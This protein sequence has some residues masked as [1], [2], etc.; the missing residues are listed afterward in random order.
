MAQLGNYAFAADP[1][2]GVVWRS[3]DN[4]AN[5]VSSRNGVP[6]F[7]FSGFSAGIGQAVTTV[8]TRVLL[9]TKIWGI[10]ASDDLGT[11]WVEANNGIALTPYQILPF[12]IGTAIVTAANGNVFAGIDGTIFYSTNQGVTWNFAINGLPITGVRRMTT[13]GAK[14]YATTQNSFLEID[15]ATLSIQRLPFTGMDT[16]Q[17]DAFYAHNGFLY[18][19]GASSLKRLSLNT[20]TRQN[21]APAFYL[22][23]VGGNKLAGQSQTFSA[24][25][26][27][28]LPI[29]YQWRKG[30]Q[31]ITGATNASYIINTLIALDAGTYDVVAT[32]PGGTATSTIASVS[33]QTIVPGAL[34]STFPPNTSA[35]G[36][37]SASVNSGTA[38]QMLAFDPLPGGSYWMAGQIDRVRPNAAFANSDLIRI[39]ADF[40]IAQD[41]LVGNGANPAGGASIEDLLRDSQGRLLAAG[42]LSHPNPNA[43]T[44]NVVRFLPNNTADSS[45]KLYMTNAAGLKVIVIKEYPGNKYII[46]GTFTNVQGQA[47]N[48]LARINQDGS[49]DTAFDPFSGLTG[50]S[51]QDV[52]V[53]PDGAVLAAGSMV[54]SVGEF[55][56]LLVRFTSAGVIDP[57]FTRIT[58]SAGGTGYAVLALPNGKIML[59]GDY[60][61]N[62]LLR[63]LNADGTT[64]SSFVQG[65]FGGSG[66]NVRAFEYQPDGKILVAGKFSSYNG[67]THD[68]IFRLLQDGS[69][70]LS[71][72]FPRPTTIPAGRSARAVRASADGQYIYVGF[73]SGTSSTATYCRY[74]NSFD[75]PVIAAHPALT[76][77]LKN[78]T[79]TLRADVFSTSTIT[80][81]W[82]KNG[83][84]IDG[85]TTNTLTLNN[86]Q[87]SDTGAYTLQATT[88]GITLTSDAGN[89]RV[90]AAPVLA[91]SPVSL[92][93]LGGK[94]FNIPVDVYGAPQMI[95]RWYLDGVRITNNFHGSSYLN[96]TNGTLS[97]TLARLPDAGL[98]QL[99]AS[100][101]LGM[102][103]SSVRVVIIP[104]PAHLSPTYV[105]PGT[106]AQTAFAAGND[107]A[108]IVSGTNIFFPAQW[109]PK[110]GIHVT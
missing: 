41:A 91:S 78:G 51:I 98:Y 84:A 8:G 67:V 61:G 31:P 7:P 2:D 57:N 72:D 65:A 68:S 49:L 25:A 92:S 77:V 22:H 28:T 88:Q 12:R 42:D 10:Y 80:Y 105:G 102:V 39:A 13:L 21:F 95:L 6:G 83:V 62:P 94:P 85:A 32:G 107:D 69:L 23:P 66:P 89:L 58:A 35:T 15:A 33:V 75:N 59:G 70:D 40:T 82:F 46:G 17:D 56:S 44:T 101:N 87:E 73:E 34:D 11:T 79:A 81:Q 100:N 53:L 16:V 45:F 29:T 60:L 43:Y 90:L 4:G 55:P 3:T 18:V 9:A 97:N 24:G 108:A 106:G 110:L 86:V 52:A 74:L 36:N 104:Q 14:V 1:L 109:D 50:T 19:G 93:V 96:I 103:T 48:R 27:G 54:A 71:V 63:R 30:G 38:G 5:W 47:R 76:S 99:V 26:S 37:A 20:A 64:D